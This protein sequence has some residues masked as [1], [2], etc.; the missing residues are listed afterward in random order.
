MKT[1][2]SI[3]VIVCLLTLPGM[4]QTSTPQGLNGVNSQPANGARQPGPNNGGRSKPTAESLELMKIAFITKRL[5]LSAEEAEKF[6]PIYYRYAAEI[7]EA[8][9]AYR[10]HKNE[11]AL[12]ETILNIKK[13][14][15]VEFGKALPPERVNAFFRADKDFGGFVQKEFQRRQMQVQPKK[16][17]AGER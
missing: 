14:Y 6:W 2:I 11:L 9:A 4:P 1:T 7:R 8:H 13:K 5:N 16:P 3:F 12:D 10:Q 17:L 15:S